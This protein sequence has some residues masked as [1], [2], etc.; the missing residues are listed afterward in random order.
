MLWAWTGVHFVFEGSWTHAHYLYR[1]RSENLHNFMSNLGRNGLLGSSRGHFTRTNPQ[2]G[3]R[4]YNFRYIP[5]T[6]GSF[7]AFAP[8]KN[9]EIS[10]KYSLS[11][12][13]LAKG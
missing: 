12:Y 10:K 11:V 4:G 1:L 2:G 3:D 9:P 8:G 6:F 13:L 5:G 7:A